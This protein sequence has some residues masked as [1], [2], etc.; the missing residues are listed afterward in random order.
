MPFRFTLALVPVAAFVAA[1][2]LLGRHDAVGDPD[3]I[4]IVSSLPRSGSAR[5]QTDSIVNGIR[6]AFDEVNYKIEL[7][8][9]DTQERRSYRIE[10]E[11]LDDATAAAGQWTIEQETANANQAR[12]DPDVLVYIGTHN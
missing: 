6:I 10:Y 3:V 2:L 8:D 9:P 5:G 4:R 1:G 11:D 7:T 12:M